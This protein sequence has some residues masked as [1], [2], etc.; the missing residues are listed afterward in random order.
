MT[1]QAVLSH[2]R[3]AERNGWLPL[4]KD[5]AG[6]DLTPALLLAI[7]SRESAL[8]K[9]LDSSW[10]GDNG[11]AWGIMQIDRRAH[12]QWTE[13]HA[14]NDHAANV[15]KGADVLRSEV[16]YFGRLRPALASYNT[17]RGAVETALSKGIS[18]D[19]YTTGGDYTEDVLRRAEWIAEARPSLAETQWSMA[20]LGGIGLALGGAY[21]VYHT[22]SN[23]Q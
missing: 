1:K 7:G 14:P 23:R 17:T 8:G 9:A 4:F 3:H 21:A 10:K 15:Q 19:T 16:E 11:N 18:V 6:S 2:V 22:T 20:M 13:R 12:P 5:A